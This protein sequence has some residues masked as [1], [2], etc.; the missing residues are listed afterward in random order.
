MDVMIKR[1]KLCNSKRHKLCTCS[2]HA[3][4]ETKSIEKK[5]EFMKLSYEFKVRM[6]LGLVMFLGG[7]GILF[8]PFANSIANIVIGFSLGYMIVLRVK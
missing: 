3:K 1:Y 8:I 7:I 6:I 2:K 4:W 5:E